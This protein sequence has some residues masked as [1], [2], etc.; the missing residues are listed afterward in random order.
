MP[1]C[2]TLQVAHQGL[3]HGCP[4]ASD[5]WL[6]LPNQEREPQDHRFHAYYAVIFGG[7]D[8]YLQDSDDRRESPLCDHVNRVRKKYQPMDADDLAGP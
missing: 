6:T 7:V 4:L 1:D 2:G 5:A 3:C 8:N